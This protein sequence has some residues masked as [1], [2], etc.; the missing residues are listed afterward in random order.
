MKRNEDNVIYYN[1]ENKRIFLGQ[2]D[3]KYIG[4]YK[5]VFSSGKMYEE[6]NG[7]DLFNFSKGDIM[8]FYCGLMRT[9]A[10]SLNNINSALKRYTDWAITE[11]LVADNMNHYSEVEYSNLASCVNGSAIER[12]LFSIERL[13]NYADSMW[14]S[15]EDNLVNW[16]DLAVIYLIFE[17]IRGPHY[18]EILSLEFNDVYDCKVRTCTGRIVEI[19]QSCQRFVDRARKDVDYVLPS[20]KRMPFLDDK[21]FRSYR[22][23]Q[24]NKELSDKDIEIL[25]VRRLQR[26]LS[27]LLE[28][29]GYDNVTLN[30]III[31]GQINYVQQL[32]NKANQP[33]CDYIITNGC[34][35]YVVE[36][37]GIKTWVGYK[38]YEKFRKALDSE[39]SM[40]EATMFIEPFKVAG[41]RENEN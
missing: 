15:A 38:F 10:D 40:D 34:H 11:S 37:Y 19:S 23:D 13:L 22:K 2:C 24:M 41:E 3:K 14:E 29:M 36:R 31:S 5:S 25:E 12:S 17:G 16:C 21:I 32:A 33:I 26:R 8:S 1:N 20:G 6:S 39:I 4:L 18:S 9:S 30:S 35:E 28:K 7:K 27:V